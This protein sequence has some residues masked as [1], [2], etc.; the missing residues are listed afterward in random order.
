[1]DL[2]E[3]QNLAPF[4]AYLKETRNTI[5]GREP[6]KLL[7]AIMEEAQ[8]ATSDEYQTKFVNYA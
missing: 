3:G 6:I 1:M 7:L 2:I 4:E 5:C 8:K